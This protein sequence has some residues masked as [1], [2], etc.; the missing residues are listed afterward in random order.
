MERRL[1]V[2]H[3]GM[4]HMVS[5]LREL[6]GYAPDARSLLEPDS[7]S[8][9]PRV[10]G[11]LGAGIGLSRGVPSLTEAVRHA[12]EVLEPVAA[13][14]A[15]QLSLSLP[16]TF[17]SLPARGMFS[18]VAT[19]LRNSIEAIRQRRASDAPSNGQGAD[20]SNGS[21]TS[22]DRARFGTIDITGGILQ[23]PTRA[24]IEVTDDGVGLSLRPGDHPDRFFD[25]GFTT[26]PNSS[27]IGLAVARD[28]V[29]RL[30][31]SISLMQRT[32][33]LDTPRPPSQIHPEARG[34]VLRIEWPVSIPGSDQK[35]GT[36]Q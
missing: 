15:I 27:G 2:V 25:L 7:L 36:C 22:P 19:A 18:I 1:D 33:T 20:S 11:Q 30:G 14:A 28:T 32:C 23:Q 13:D 34:A 10:I 8:L 35:G 31:G 29:R 24:W 6:S 4:S 26:K 5:L 17:D 21:I 16:Q 3:A 12:A 9:D